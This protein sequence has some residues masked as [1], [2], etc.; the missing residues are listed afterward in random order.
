MY[1][2][3]TLTAFQSIEVELY[4]DAFNAATKHYLSVETG[5]CGIG[6]IW[7]YDGTSLTITG[8]GSMYD[9]DDTANV[10]WRAY[11]NEIPRV[12]IGIGVTKVGKNAFNGCTA[13][14]EVSLPM[15]LKWIGDNAFRGCT[16]LGSIALPDSVNTIGTAAFRG[17]SSLSGIEF[18]AGVTSIP[19]ECCYGCSSMHAP[20]IPDAVTSIGASA[21]EGGKRVYL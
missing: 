6:V 16:A 19:D 18:P 10:P 14:T 9:W 12:Q 4:N 21:F 11:V 15:T 8:N 5:A 7:T 13:L 2:H 3:G 1:Y 20:G 17:C